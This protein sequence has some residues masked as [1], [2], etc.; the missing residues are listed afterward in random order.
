MPS[1]WLE[2]AEKLSAFLESGDT[3]MFFQDA[4]PISVAQTSLTGPPG[5]NQT[6]FEVNGE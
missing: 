3:G 1:F 5:P 6:A 2:V 4:L